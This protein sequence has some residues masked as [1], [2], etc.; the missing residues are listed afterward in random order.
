MSDH[1]RTYA[2]HSDQECLRLKRQAVLADIDGHLTIFHPRAEAASA[3][4]RPRFLAYECS[5]SAAKSSQE[6]RNEN[7]RI[8]V[9]RSTIFSFAA[10]APEA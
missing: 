9:Q 4:S 5:A 2:I 6:D 7:G 1:S 3:V 8:V 10:L